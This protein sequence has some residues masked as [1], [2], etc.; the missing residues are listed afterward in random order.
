[1]LPVRIEKF[2]VWFAVENGALMLSFEQEPPKKMR[3]YREVNKTL[4][5][6]IKRRY[7][8]DEV[9]VEVYEDREWAS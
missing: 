1:M 6:E 4:Y 8:I 3:C 7:P 2:G 5:D 9:K